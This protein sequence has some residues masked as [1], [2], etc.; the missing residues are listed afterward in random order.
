VLVNNGDWIVRF[1]VERNE[2]DE[3][4]DREEISD[5]FMYNGGSKIEVEKNT[6][7][8]NKINQ[9]KT[10][11]RQKSDLLLIQKQKILMKKIIQEK[12]DKDR[13]K[14]GNAKKPR[15]RIY[16]GIDDNS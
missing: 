6:M 1:E 12:E 3:I 16:K 5:N 9:K 13:M 4:C 10:C 2:H 15:I 14:V 7:N 8:R 11:K